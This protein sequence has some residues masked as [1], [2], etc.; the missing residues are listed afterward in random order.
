VIPRGTM[1]DALAGK[2]AMVTGASRGIGRAIAHKLAA[3]DREPSVIRE[4]KRRYHHYALHIRQLSH[5]LEWLSVMQHHGAPTRLLDWT[6][7]LHVAAYFGA[8]SAIATEDADAAIWLLNDDG[9]PTPP[10]LFLGKLG[11][12]K[13]PTT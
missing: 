9:A 2:I 8:E 7:S 10:K 6:Y 3:Q 12:T 4:F 11:M 13:R 1:P 5:D